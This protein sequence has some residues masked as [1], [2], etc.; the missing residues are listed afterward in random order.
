V[1]REDGFKDEDMRMGA[2]VTFEA[3]LRLAEEQGS[4]DGRFHATNEELA[5]KFSE[6]MHELRGEA[7]QLIPILAPIIASMN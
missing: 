1:D 5:A 4:T 7:K 2:L 6:V 3:C